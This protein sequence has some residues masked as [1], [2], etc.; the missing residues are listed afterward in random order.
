[1]AQMTVS[2]DC[3]CSLL[4]ALFNATSQNQIVCLR[5]SRFA[6]LYYSL[7]SNLTKWVAKTET[8]TKEYDASAEI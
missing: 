1:M 3:S 8:L 2:C 4:Y 7:V 6:N 5:K